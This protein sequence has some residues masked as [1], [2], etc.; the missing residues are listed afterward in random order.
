MKILEVSQVNRYIK[1]LFSKDL[2]L[3]EIWIKGEISN[4]KHH[5]SGHMYFT[6]KD[7][8]STLKCVMF[9]TQASKLRFT[10]ADG[11][12][13]IVFGRVSVF[14][15]DGQYQLYCEEM[16]PDGIG[17][18]YVA[19]EQLKAKLEKEGLFSVSH[20]KNIPLLPERI[21]VVT[22]KTGAVIR[23]IINVA[24]RRFPGVQIVLFPVAVQGSAAAGE[25]TNAIE[26]FN[27][28]KNID[29]IIVARG[30]G[31]LEDLWAFN[32]EIVARAIFNSEIPVISA[33]GHETD[34]TIADMTADFRAPTP[35]AAAEIAVPERKELEF[36]ILSNTKRIMNS[37]Q[38]RFVSLQ[39]RLDRI[40]S[41][42]PFRQPL[43]RVCQLKMLLDMVTKS[44]IRNIALEIQSEKSRI[45]NQAL[46]LG[47]LN[48]LSILAR[49]YCVA[50]NSQTGKILKSIEGVCKN[51]KINIKFIDGKALC[52]VINTI[53][54]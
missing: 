46:R 27:R 1:E 42:T 45:S 7:N 40:Q 32:E 47:A 14:E 39:N 19:F 25:I 24:S 31:S 10:P 13:I 54:N 33:V 20:K 48:P 15:R 26:A 2:L 23:D 36:R 35:S 41:R 34:Y 11:M 43:D 18:L 29:A 4:F 5:S 17:T 12:K 3:N 53:D 28:V 44:L 52:Q 8:S 38:K 30:G 22:S 16:Q 6:L 37:L 49:G 50:E 51:Q 9:Q 21:G